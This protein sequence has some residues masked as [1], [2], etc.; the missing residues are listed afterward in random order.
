[1]TPLGGLMKVL[2]GGLLGW[3]FV[4]GALSRFVDAAAA[5]VGGAASATPTSTTGSGPTASGGMA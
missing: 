3:A 1:V 4:S 2:L 5:G